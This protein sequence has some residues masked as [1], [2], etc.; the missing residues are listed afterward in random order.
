MDRG[1]RR[2]LDHESTSVKDCS[3]VTPRTHQQDTLGARRF[4]ADN[5]VMRIRLPGLNSAPKSHNAGSLPTYTI[6]K[7]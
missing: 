1:D 4:S 5:K 3:S 2:S 7:R 6:S